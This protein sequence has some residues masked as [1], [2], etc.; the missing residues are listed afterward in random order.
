[1]VCLERLKIL[2][3]QLPPHGRRQSDPLPAST[4]DTSETNPQ[5]RTWHDVTAEVCLISL[6]VADV[7][8]KKK[9]LL[10][11]ESESFKIKLVHLELKRRTQ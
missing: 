7:F 5:Q 3:S 4:A 11:R 8:T 1:M 9:R 10:I 2:V 6:Y